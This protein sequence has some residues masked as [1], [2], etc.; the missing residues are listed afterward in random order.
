M[1]S[2]TV[3][4]FVPFRT[5]S[6]AD[7]EKLIARHRGGELHKNQFVSSKSDKCRNCLN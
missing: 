2:V 1:F 6:A 5:V 7:E 3:I 4:Y